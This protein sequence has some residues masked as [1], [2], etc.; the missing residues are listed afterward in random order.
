MSN[1]HLWA[2]P[3]EGVINLSRINVEEIASKI[4]PK[5]E[6]QYLSDLKKLVVD[7]THEANDIVHKESLLLSGV[8]TSLKNHIERF[9]V[10]LVQAVVDRLESEKN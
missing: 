4:A 1:V 2:N 8:A 3:Y 9:T 7:A 5:L 6:D 10:E